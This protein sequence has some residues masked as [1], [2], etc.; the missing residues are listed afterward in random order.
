[1]TDSDSFYRS[2]LDS[3]HDGVYFVDRDRRITY[4]NR[5]A[6]SLTGYSAEE[7]VGRRCADALL[8][9]VD[10][11]GTCLCTAGCPLA[12][13]IQ[14]GQP[15]T[16]DV[17]LHHKEGHRVPVNVRAAPLRDATGAIVG[18][19]ETFS[20]NSAKVSALERVLAL[21]REAHVDHLTGLMTRR[22]LEQELRSRLHELSRYKW[23][24]GVVF[25]DIDHF[26]T[27]NDV[28]GH[29]IG[30]RLLRS[31][32]LTLLNNLRS[33]DA[34]GRWGGDEFVVVLA[35][36]TADE[37][38]R[39]GNRMRRLVEQ[40]SVKVGGESLNVT[41][42]AGGT[43]AHPDDT[44]EAVVRRADALMYRSK[45]SGRNQVTVAT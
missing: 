44:P 43:V 28:Y 1:M 4:W 20:D 19:V 2:V 3:L 42:S 32:G 21:E 17:Y 9:H 31:T 12:A 33:F 36:V 5:G 24:C 34:A 6:A 10:A 30:D 23:P 11:L 22:Y 29:D 35:N 16:A 39:V 26:K 27:I 40:S 25:L 13:T 8:M 41:V 37:V 14:D 38:L 18:A 45:E 7:A 15:R